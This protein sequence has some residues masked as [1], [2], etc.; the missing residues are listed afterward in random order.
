MIQV[1]PSP[2]P[3]LPPPMVG[4][5]SNLLFCTVPLRPPPPPPPPPPCGVVWCGC[6]RAVLHC[7]PPPPLQP[8]P[9]PR[10]SP[11]CASGF[12]SAWSPAPPV[13]WCWVCSHSLR[14][15]IVILI[16]TLLL[17]LIVLTI[18]IIII[19]FLSW[20]NFL[21]QLPQDRRG[22]GAVRHLHL[23]ERGGGWGGGGGEPGT[24]IIYIYIYIYI[25]FFFFFFFF[26]GGGG[27]RFDLGVRARE[28]FVGIFREGLPEEGG[29][30]QPPSRSLICYYIRYVWYLHTSPTALHRQPFFR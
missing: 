27:G 13:V 2:P 6:A 22:E 5:P 24:G 16:I 14:P 17:I 15:V 23:R 11:P 7:S 1:R 21:G 19:M 12:G 20:V 3:P 4:N 10:P 9:P 26:W 25:Y 30:M 28:W 29:C 18:I 8:P